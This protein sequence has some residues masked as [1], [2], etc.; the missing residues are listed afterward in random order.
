MEIV[1]K[2]ADRTCGRSGGGLKERRD[3][4]RYLLFG[5]GCIG[6]F[7]KLKLAAAVK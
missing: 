6:E 3:E 7:K 1:R 2:V 5:R 4:K